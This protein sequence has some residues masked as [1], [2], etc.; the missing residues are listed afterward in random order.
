MP[1]LDVLERDWRKAVKIVRREYPHIKEGSPEF[2]ALVFGVVKR[3][4][5]RKSARHLKVIL[6]KARAYDPITFLPYMFNVKVRGTDLW[7]DLPPHLAKEPPS[8]YPSFPLKRGEFVDR[9][10]ARIKG[11]LEDFIEKCVERFI[12]HPI[13]VS[14]DSIEPLLRGALRLYET[15][16]IPQDEEVSWK[17]IWIYGMVNGLIQPVTPRWG[18]RLSLMS[19]KMRDLVTR[20]IHEHLSVSPPT[21]PLSFVP[22]IVV[23]KPMLRPFVVISPAEL[24]TAVAILPYQW[25]KGGAAA[26]WQS[27]EELISN[28]VP[29]FF[30]Y[31]LDVAGLNKLEEM[32]F[33]IPPVLNPYKVLCVFTNETVSPEPTEFSVFR[34]PENEEEFKLHVRV[35]LRRNPKAIEGFKEEL[36]ATLTPRWI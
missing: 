1:T 35:A 32:R 36:R 15:P 17:L 29:A 26:L 7:M 8:S 27:L 6:G 22:D 5:G 25:R 18:Y 19:V 14:V 12:E 28:T 31:A 10:R 23:H 24:G 9:V 11:N 2:W 34:M 30:A 3:M 21:D 16:T 13:G 20:R 33:V 4:R